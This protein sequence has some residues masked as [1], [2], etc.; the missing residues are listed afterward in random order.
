[1]N[2]IIYINGIRLQTSKLR[3]RRRLQVNDLA[4]L[5]NRQSNFTS[6]IQI[7][8]TSINLKAFQMVGE[9]GAVTNLP[10]QKL[11]ARMLSESG[12]EIVNNGW[13]II[14]R[15][16]DTLIDFSIYDGYISFWKAIENKTFEEIDT[17]LLEHTLNVQEVINSWN[18]DLPYRYLISDF[19]GINRLNSGSTQYWNIDYQVPCVR[20]SFLWNQ[21]FDLIGFTY[22][23]SVFSSNDFTKRY[24][25]YPNPTE[26][27]EPNFLQ[28]S[29]QSIGQNPVSLLPIPFENDFFRN[30]PPQN[31]SREFKINCVVE[32]RKTGS[33]NFGTINSN[34]QN[35]PFIRWSVRDNNNFEHQ[36]GFINDEIV[37]IYVNAGENLILHATDSNDENNYNICTFFNSG[38]IITRIRFAESIDLNLLENFKSITFSQFINEVI[39]S[40]GLTPFTDN[41]TNHID[42]LTLDEIINLPVEDWSDKFIKR[43]NSS[44]QFSN[45]AQK[46]IFKYKYDID[47]KK[48]EDGVIEINN[49]NISAERT[50]FESMFFAPELVQTSLGFVTNISQFKLFQQNVKQTTSGP[51]VEVKILG[52]KF[53]TML[54]EE[55][56]ETIPF[57]SQIS[58]PIVNVSNY[59]VSKFEDL[60]FQNLIEKYYSPFNDIL[61]PFE[62]IIAE[63]RLTEVEYQHFTL[64][65]LRY[66][67]Q[68]GGTFLVNSLDFIDEETP[69][70]VELIKLNK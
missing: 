24:M 23:G 47:L 9:L 22:S 60:S 54:E 50:E 67:E 45:Y 11:S 12:E 66:I 64:K 15:V 21:I 8:K 39:V 10:Y 19:G 6:N 65:K 51:E 5:R 68:L 16:T 62:L 55:S 32:L 70:R 46:N 26:D 2:Y 7:K 29:I 30:I 41:N 17:E 14:N 42:F 52:E 4:S 37:L 58:G 57:G 49:E 34:V 33:V 25:T 59:F 69:V 28:G 53:F 13:A 27:I 61:N 36:Y 35:F 63:V 31:G 20:F 56:N 43:I 3:I 40:Y 44:Y 18:N 38:N 1:M 48:Y